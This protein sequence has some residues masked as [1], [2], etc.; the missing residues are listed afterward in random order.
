MKQQIKIK[1]DKNMGITVFRKIQLL[2]ADGIEV[3]N[4]YSNDTCLELPLSDSNLDTE[5]ADCNII[6]ATAFLYI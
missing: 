4:L 6:G 3:F 5:L 1:R 2:K